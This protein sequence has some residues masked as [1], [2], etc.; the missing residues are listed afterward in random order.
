M[1]ILV[2]LLLAVLVTGAG[3]FGWTQYKSSEERILAIETVQVSVDLTERQLK[4]RK[5]SEIT[6]G[7]Y[8]KSS[9]AAIEQLDAG[10]S[11]LEA[12]KWQYHRSDRDVAVNFLEQCKVIV[13]SDQAETRLLMDKSNAKKQVDQAQREVEEAETPE[14]ID[15]RL[16][17]YNRANDE[18]IAVM[19]KQIEAV[20]HSVE[21]IKQLIAADDSVKLAFGN[22]QGFTETTIAAMKKYIASEQPKEADNG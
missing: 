4:A 18:L 11:N 1:K 21:K 9:A 8:F 2:A 13:W 12:H 7:E 6:V 17:Q 22:D 3:W 20:K 15:W 16:K 19:Q 14:A 5:E 10:I